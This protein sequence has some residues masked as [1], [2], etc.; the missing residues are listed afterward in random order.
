MFQ[1]LSGFS[2]WEQFQLKN[3]DH[4][5]TQP[6]TLFDNRKPE[7]VEHAG[8]RLH[9]LS[10][11]PLITAL[12]TPHLHRAVLIKA[13]VKLKMTLPNRNGTN[14]S[15]SR[16]QHS[17]GSHYRPV[18]PRCRWSVTV[19]VS[20]VDC[21]GRWCAAVKVTGAASQGFVLSGQVDEQH[22]AQIELSLVLLHRGKLFYRPTHVHNEANTML[23]RI[24]H[25]KPHLI[26]PHAHFKLICA[27][28]F[29]ISPVDFK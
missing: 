16:R 1:I 28:M 19:R 29:R 3:H 21:C 14:S 17:E 6:G 24:N 23:P 25:L 5:P 22:S 10:K 27:L 26:G 11:Q 18:V 2:F 9:F 4:S 8:I 20:V 15:H 7:V 12:I 13:A